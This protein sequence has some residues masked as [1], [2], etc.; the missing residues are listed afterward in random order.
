MG[1]IKSVNDLEKI[2]L[3]PFSPAEVESFTSQ[4]LKEH[5][6]EFD[7]EIICRIQELLGEPIPYF[8]QLLTQ[9]LYR[10]WKRNRG[11]KYP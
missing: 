7:P 10:H 6:V 1:E 4:M 2:T 5:E 3:P 8:L 11:E 9:E